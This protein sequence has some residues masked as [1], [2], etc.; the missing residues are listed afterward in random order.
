MVCSNGT[1]GTCTPDGTARETI[2]I[3]RDTLGIG[4]PTP[5][6]GNPCDPDCRQYADTP[7]DTLSGVGIVASGGGLTLE[8]NDA[9]AVRDDGW[10]IRDYDASGACEA[11]TV[12]YWSFF[13]W[14]A[15]TPGDSHI[16][17]EIA[18]AESVTALP[19]SRVDALLFSNPPGPVSLA[20]EPVSIQRGSP[21]TELGAVIVDTTLIAK[22]RS[23][24]MNAM[25]IR[26]HLVASEDKTE[27]PLLKLWSQFISCQPTE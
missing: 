27:A 2:A 9:G 23:R 11:G 22:M 20:G 26:A 16:D 18:V 7:D 15:S 13:A 25:R 21:N 17:V 4:T 1:W 6:A 10:F 3:G 8:R 14:N 12:P 5:C 19:A 24:T